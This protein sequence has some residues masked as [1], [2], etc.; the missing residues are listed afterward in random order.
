MK[1]I[2]ELGPNQKIKILVHIHFPS[3]ECAFSKLVIQVQNL[4]VQKSIRT[5]DCSSDQVKIQESILIKKLEPNHN[6]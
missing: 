2:Q 1:L 3:M 5:R 6:I 4:Q